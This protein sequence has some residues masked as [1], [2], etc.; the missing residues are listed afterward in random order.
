VG[1]DEST[2]FSGV[3]GIKGP[4]IREQWGLTERCWSKPVESRAK[5]WQIRQTKRC[6][7]SASWDKRRDPVLLARREEED[8]VRFLPEGMLLVGCWMQ[9]DK[10][11]K[12]QGKK[13]QIR[14]GLLETMAENRVIKG[15]LAGLKVGT[16]IWTRGLNSKKGNTRFKFVQ[17]HII[18]FDW[19]IICRKSIFIVNGHKKCERG[20]HVYKSG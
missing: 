20:H 12:S 18:E 13:L 15:W 6:C 5:K 17:I 4:D 19:Y 3:G 14:G 8:K 2:A 9:K 1:G 7:G 11:R 16:W 10:G